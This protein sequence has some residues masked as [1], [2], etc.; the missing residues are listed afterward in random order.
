MIE[1]SLPGGAPRL[2]PGTDRIVCPGH[3]MAGASW[4]LGPYIG[5]LSG[6]KGTLR[7][8]IFASEKSF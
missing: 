4:V 6:R 1:G 8:T 2:R 5:A 3:Q 7:S